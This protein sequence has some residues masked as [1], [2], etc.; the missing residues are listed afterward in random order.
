MSDVLTSAQARLQ[1][2]L[3]GL[4]KGD[5]QCDDVVLQ[6]YSFDG[7][8]LE[9]RPAAVVWPRSAQ[10]VAAVMTYAREKGLSVHPRG[11]GTSGGAAAI[12]SGI[13]LDFTRHMRRVLQAGDYFARVQP[14]A[15]R[16]RV[17]DQLRSTKKRFFAPS[18][19]HLPLSTIGS[20]LSV[21]VVG[22]RWLR[23]GSPHESALALKVVSAQGKI[24]DLRP[25]TAR[26]SCN[27]R[28]N[29]LFRRRFLNVAAA[30]ANDEARREDAPDPELQP[31]Y[32]P[33]FDVELIAACEGRNM[34]DFAVDDA[35]APGG[36][37]FFNSEFARDLFLL[38]AFGD[39]ARDVKTMLRSEPW[40][41][42]LRVVRQYEPYL[43]QEQRATRPI[44]CGYALRDVV[45]SGFDPTRFFT[46]SE[47]TLGVI[48]EATVATTPIAPANAAAILLFDSLD[49][50][51]R[52][53]ET[54]RS[55]AP[56]LCDLLDSRV[57]A[58]TRDWDARFES[59]FPQGAAA[60]LVVELDDEN[61]ASLR[62]R[63]ND[64]L[65]VAREKLDSF[66]G[67]TAYSPEERAL[68]RE[69][70]QKSSCA[71]LRMAPSFQPFPYWEDVQIPVENAPEFIQ[72]IQSFCKRERIVYSI[73][74][75]VGIGQLSVQ[76]IIPYSEDEERRVF[77]LSDEFEKIVLSYG[78][79]I[80]AAKGNG[81]VR[82]AAIPKRFPKLF[83]AFVAVKR[84]FDRDNIL[85]PDCVVSPE[86]RRM[87]DERLAPQDD[88]VE[89]GA[90]AILA[91]EADA[92]LR[93][94][95]H[96]SRS[97]RRRAPFDLQR[98]ERDAKID[99][100]NRRDR[101]QFEFQIAWNPT[102]VYAHA[103]RCVGCGRCRIRTK[104]TRL[105]PAFRNAPEEH[106][107]CRAKANLLRGALDGAI[108]L[109]ALALEASYRIAKHCLRCHSCALE[110]PAQVDAAR[111][112]IRLRG[113]YVAANGFELAELFALR[114]DLFL[115]LGSRLAPLVNFALRSP[116]WRWTLEKAFGIA[117]ARKLPPIAPRPRLSKAALARDDD[118]KANAEEERLGIILA[119]AR[120]SVAGVPAKRKV[121]LLV[122]SYENFF[123]GK[124]VDAALEIL[125]RSGV[126]A[127]VLPRP[128][129]IGQIAFELGDV[130]RA[131]EIAE[132]NIVILREAIRDG[133]AIVALEPSSVACV[134]KDYPY[135]C[136]DDDAR[137]VYD[138]VFD[139]CSYLLAAIRREEIDP[140]T[141]RPLRDAPIAAGYHAPCRSLALAGA[142]VATETPAETLLKLIP[143]LQVKRLERG[144]CG[145]AGYQGLTTLR[146]AKSQRLGSRLFLAMRQSGIDLCLSECSLCN[147]QIAQGANKPVMH[148]IKA[149]AVAYGVAD[150]QDSLLQVFSGDKGKTRR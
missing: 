135:F 148:A 60:A 40:A 139:F 64:M 113:A 22:P 27:P 15:V 144:C 67:W 28:A 39:D 52:A 8:P 104:E 2:D 75:Y 134:K 93:E 124:L 146:H 107:S 49:Q 62:R 91:P 94:S 121:A 87:V 137:A 133:S 77:A 132:R 16:E 85:N 149:L 138:N 123:D 150:F 33:T 136:D 46:G 119:S 66:G 31:S 10:D 82:T 56:T 4:V 23:Y 120:L 41:S 125:R 96:H 78:G 92:A 141:L 3:R 59:I 20:I 19:G 5:A 117:R 127:R 143:N 45:R 81:R 12:G 128:K 25:F 99:W 98:L 29:E 18:A 47:G 17:N 126:D 101:S 118:A 50:T 9:E 131:Q 32:D 95:G 21:D 51:A 63:M 84:A 11:A 57:I 110:C 88:E 38:R 147:L 129:S 97:V 74:G 61:E 30:E 24:W 55:F 140:P 44:R 36:L 115:T 86:M 145:L 100:L 89:R 130:D 68:F 13:I 106:A 114:L 35:D 54:I 73:G 7:G 65:R 26:L 112:A 1:E 79:E 83:Q 58:L 116:F 42:A 105:C 48:V 142:A 14:G 111:L 90:D 71:R 122:D 72:E 103:H 53:V 76:P 108:P 43:D 34:P 102:L 37:R 6:L 80:G 109:D 69:L 70:L